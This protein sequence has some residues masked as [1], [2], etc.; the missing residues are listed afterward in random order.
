M[1]VQ[2]S[3]LQLLTQAFTAGRCPPG[4]IQ[5]IVLHEYKGTLEQLDAE[6][7]TCDP[8]EP[9][10]H[11]SFHY[12]IDNCNIHQ[13]VLD[14]NTAWSIQCPAVDD[15]GDPVTDPC[16]N[17]ENLCCVPPTWP[18]AAGNPGVDPNCYTLNIAVAVGSAAVGPCVGNTNYSVQTIQCL[19]NLIC[20]LLF[21]YSIP[22]TVNTVWRHND[23]LE[24]LPYSLLADCI[25]ECL[26]A[27]APP[28]SGLCRQIFDLPVAVPPVTATF[29]FYDPVSNTCGRGIPPGGGGGGQNLADCTGA[30]LPNGSQVVTCAALPTQLCTAVAARPFAGAAIGTTRFL[31][32]DCQLYDLSSFQFTL[33][34][35]ANVVLPANTQVV[36]CAS[37]PTQFCTILAA[38]PTGAPA[39]NATLVLGSDCQFHD[40]SALQLT[41]RDC[42]NVVL[43]I[44]TQV[45]TCSNLPAQV[46]TVLAA[47]PSGG[48]AVPGV[49]QLVGSDC[50][51]YTIPT[52]G[53]VVTTSGIQGDGT[54]GNPIRENFDNLP[55]AVGLPINVVVTTALQPDGARVAPATFVCQTLG[56]LAPAP[57][58]ATTR[59]VAVDAGNNCVTVD[60][61]TTCP[62]S[63]AANNSVTALSGRGANIEELYVRERHSEVLFTG[64]GAF[65]VVPNDYNLVLVDATA[66]SVTLNLPTIP[67]PCSPNHIY[68]KRIDTNPVNTVVING[69]PTIDNVASITLNTPGP[70][71][72]GAGEAAHLSYPVSLARW[73]IV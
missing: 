59:L 47:R 21:T 31:A 51:L 6:M 35:C 9:R 1:P 69:A 20:Y 64:P 4:T 61:S 48:V 15:C 8:N 11:A 10:C 29:P 38:R 62:V 33:R 58:V 72:S 14:A 36:T 17:P 25:D 45:V 3:I 42:S 65:N 26:T 34:D 13:Y 23:E 12:G 37:L 39:T 44:N 57:F 67:A 73:I 49:T 55:V 16:G 40:L 28:I 32:S 66:G 46:C 18:P 24:D 52:V 71:A 70:F 60:L 5:A 19:A 27:P 2:P 7:R 30:L 53:A 22:N 54:G 50:Q 56:A 41:L 68:I 63:F 43:P